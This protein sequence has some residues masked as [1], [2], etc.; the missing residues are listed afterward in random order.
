MF[1]ITI[2]R[3]VWAGLLA[4]SDGV[5]PGPSLCP[6]AGATERPQKNTVKFINKL[7]IQN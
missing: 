7:S 4:A 6:G 2:N 1:I 5:V 3:Q